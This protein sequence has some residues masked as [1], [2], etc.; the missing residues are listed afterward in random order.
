MCG[1]EYRTW[2]CCQ[3]SGTPSSY[4]RHRKIDQRTSSF[5]CFSN[6][7]PFPHPFAR[8]TGRFIQL[9]FT[10]AVPH[11]FWCAWMAF[12]FQ[13]CFGARR[14]PARTRN[15]AGTRTSQIASALVQA[16]YLQVTYVGPSRVAQPSRCWHRFLGGT[17]RVPQASQLED[18]DQSS[19]DVGSDKPTSHVQHRRQSPCSASVDVTG[20]LVLV[21]CHMGRA[22]PSWCEETLA[23]GLGSKRPSDHHVLWPRLLC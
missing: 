2:P 15:G 17:A 12:S 4:T 13:H 18:P 6:C 11:G 7:L 14:G 19:K 8:P 20:L 10:T 21:C 5:P 1:T 3:A 16:R 9:C 23:L 22:W